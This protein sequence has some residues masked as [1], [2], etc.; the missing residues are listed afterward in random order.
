MDDFCRCLD[1]ARAAEF[2]G[3][4]VLIFDGPGDERA[5][6]AQ[7]AEVVRPYL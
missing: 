1:L 6:L 4:Y 7:M 3:H 2:A 5:S